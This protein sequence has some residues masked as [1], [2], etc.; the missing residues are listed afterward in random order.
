MC[1]GYAQD[2]LNRGALQLLRLSAFAALHSERLEKALHFGISLAMADV[3]RELESG[4]VIFEHQ[5]FLGNSFVIGFRLASAF[6]PL[7]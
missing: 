2:L 1:Q 4:H 3:G 6:W 7:L 5:P